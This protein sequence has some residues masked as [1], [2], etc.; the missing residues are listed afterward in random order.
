MAT[1]ITSTSS[2]TQQ[3]L[4]K[5]KLLSLILLACLI[6]SLSINAFLLYTKVKKKSVQKEELTK[7]EQIEKRNRMLENQVSS[8]S[9]ENKELSQSYNE[10]FKTNTELDTKIKNLTKE[11]E[12]LKAVKEKMQSIENVRKTFELSKG[13]K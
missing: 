9:S 4:K 10:A 5:F 6:I 3:R 13:K 11:N 1:V 2:R 8:L 12:S 7:I